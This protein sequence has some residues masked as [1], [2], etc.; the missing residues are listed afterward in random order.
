[1]SRTCR[2]STTP[3]TAVCRSTRTL[4]KTDQP[5]SRLPRSSRRKLLLAWPSNRSPSGRSDR[6]EMIL[7]SSP[8]HRRPE[9][10]P[11]AEV[12]SLKSGVAVHVVGRRAYQHKRCT[13]GTLVQTISPLRPFAP[14]V[15]AAVH[16]ARRR[17]VHI[18]ARQRRC[19]AR[20]P[21][22]AGSAHALI[23]HRH[24]EHA[25]VGAV[26]GCRPGRCTRHCRPMTVK[27]PMTGW[28]ET[29]SG[30]IREPRRRGRTGSA[31]PLLCGWRKAR[32][33]PLLRGAGVKPK[34]ARAA[35]FVAL[36]FKRCQI[37]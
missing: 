17:C 35:V 20:P 4:G 26:G 32:I 12:S 10:V 34:Q 28:T 36:R 6:G 24:I 22:C 11:S 13:E 3:L 2:S 1:M 29:L 25:D 9:R 8:V 21:A 18:R 37:Q 5:R 7:Q 14:R 31:R 30:P 27:D 23:S 16:G 19:R 33:E 15:R